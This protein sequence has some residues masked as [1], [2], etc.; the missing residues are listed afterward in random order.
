MIEESMLSFFLFLF[1]DSFVFSYIYFS[2]YFRFLEHLNFGLRNLA[3]FYFFP[4]FVAIILALFV[5]A[6]TAFDAKLMSLDMCHL[7]NGV[8]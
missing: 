5:C 3:F 1:L 7:Q 6:T 4:F 2:L 8:R